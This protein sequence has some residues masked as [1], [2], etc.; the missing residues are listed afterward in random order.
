[1]SQEIAM[2]RPEMPDP[3]PDEYTRIYMEGAHTRNCLIFMD[4]LREKDAQ[5]AR[6]AAI[7]N[8]YAEDCERLKARLAAIP[9][10][11]REEDQGHDH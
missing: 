9:Q 10:F 6:Y 7:I 4:M 11:S 2:D 1:M 5:L 3:I 8:R